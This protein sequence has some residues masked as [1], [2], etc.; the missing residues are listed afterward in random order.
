MYDS[1]ISA[2]PKISTVEMVLTTDCNLRCM[3]CYMH[4][5]KQSMSVDMFMRSLDTIYDDMEDNFS[6]TLFGGEPLLNLDCVYAIPSFK[7]KYKKCGRVVL[8]TNGLLLTDDIMQFLQEHDIGISFSW[9][10]T[11]DNQNKTRP[12]AN[13]SLLTEDKAQSI[14]ALLHK[15]K[16]F[17]VKAMVDNNNVK[18]IVT[19]AVYFKNNNF[20][21][22]DLSIVRDNIWFK[23][24]IEEF[25][26]QLKLLYDLYIQ[27][28]WGKQNIYIGLFG[29]PVIDY[30]V[31]V[32]GT[33][34]EYS[35]FAGNKGLAIMP[36][37]DIYPCARF[38]TNKQML[39]GD[40]YN[41]MHTNSKQLNSRTVM[42]SAKKKQYLS[43]SCGNCS[44]NFFCFLGC[45]YSQWYENDTA[46]MPIKS[47][48]LLYKLMF[49]YGYTLYKNDSFFKNIIDKQHNKN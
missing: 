29:L 18:D 38:G 45:V 17:G 10:G 30:L 34:R 11:I 48:C 23:E 8:V 13:H 37:G 32:D 40:I 39:L 3:Y 33:S 24:D 31:G 22:I 12:L 35:C 41:G 5:E 9:D 21:Y 16:K 15:Y 4:K 7:E 6:M 14:F 46:L 26:N 43:T 49:K 36:N 19:N 20:N 28:E 27:E 2:F 42:C 44:I 1:I 47:I 25:E